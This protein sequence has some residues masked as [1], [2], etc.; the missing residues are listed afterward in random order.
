[1]TFPKLSA[2]NASWLQRL[3]K[4]LETEQYADHQ[5]FLAP[6]RRFLAYLQRKALTVHSVRTSDI[7]HYLSAQNHRHRSRRHTKLSLGR[8]IADRSKIHLLLRLVH[9]QWPLTAAPRNERESFQCELIKQFDEWLSTSRGLSSATRTSRRDSALRFLQW[10][11]ERGG[12]DKLSTLSIADVDAY[13]QWRTSRLR[14][15]TKKRVVVD[16]RS[17]LRHLHRTGRVRDFASVVVAPKLYALES[18]PAALRNDE[19]DQVLRLVRKDRSAR[20]RRDYAILTLLSTY[21]LRAGE[22]TSLRL[23]DIDWRHC[24]LRLRHSKTGMHSE[25]PLLAAPGEAILD[26]LRKGRP[27][28]ALQEV[29]LRSCAPYRALR[30]GAS[31]NANLGRRFKA[32]GIVLPRGKRGIHAFR[33][34][35]AGNMLQAGIPL[36]VIGDLLG[37]RSMGSTMS[38]LKLATDDLRAVALEIPGVVT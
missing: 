30:S 1:M 29:F 33:Y 2:D 19:I 10:L 21:G 14:R 6:L 38:Y 4:H 31:L 16:L 25:L 35:K 23:Q 9:G 15:S 13:I 34:A 5:S 20:G 7:A 12:P 36:K 17:F 28:T 11:G 32:A 22:I 26:Y 37:H 27:K 8:R 18:L 3:C 24:R